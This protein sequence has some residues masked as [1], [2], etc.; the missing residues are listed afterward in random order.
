MHA[1]GTPTCRVTRPFLYDV[2][3]WVFLTT[4]LPLL[5][6]LLLRVLFSLRFSCLL[7]YTYCGST[8]SSSGSSSSRSRSSGTCSSRVIS[9]SIT[10]SSH[11]IKSNTTSLM[12][13]LR[14]CQ[15]IQ[16]TRTKVIKHTAEALETGPIK[17]Q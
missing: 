7:L 16:M 15:Q 12:E 6:P 5:P 13:E 9:S 3:L 17:P 2:I 14:R 8:E 1:I 4:P 11:S 10:L